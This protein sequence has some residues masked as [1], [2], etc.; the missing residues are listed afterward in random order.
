MKRRIRYSTEPDAVYVS[1]YCA[2]PSHADSEWLLRSFVWVPEDD[3]KPA[4]AWHWEESHNYWRDQTPDVRLTGRT[5]ASLV[6][7]RHVSQAEWKANPFVFDAGSRT[8]YR[9]HCETC[10]LTV[11]R[12]APVVYEVLAVLA[13]AGQREV[14]L[15]VLKRAL[16][17]VAARRG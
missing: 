13:S 7:D 14:S 11:V 8:R 2:E 9:F 1:I 3:E 12:K 17:V 15:R 16:D 5:R 10:G 4:G 6:G